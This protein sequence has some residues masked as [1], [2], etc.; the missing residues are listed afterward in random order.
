MAVDWAE[1]E[2][3][4]AYPVV[5][6]GQQFKNSTAADKYIDTLDYG[7]ERLQGQTSFIKYYKKKYHGIIFPGVKYAIKYRKD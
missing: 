1:L 2:E 7:L 4:K 5:I 3:D 6:S